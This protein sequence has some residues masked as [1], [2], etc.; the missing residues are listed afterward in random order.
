[1]EC[2]WMALLGWVA[3]LLAHASI[4]KQVVGDDIGNNPPETDTYNC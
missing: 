3:W 2:V 4:L 1:M